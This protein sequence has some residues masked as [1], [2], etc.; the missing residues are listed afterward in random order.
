MRNILLD[1][2]WKIQTTVCWGR[3]DRWF[4]YD[5]VEEFCKDSKHNLI[6]L[7]MVVTASSYAFAEKLK[8]SIIKIDIIN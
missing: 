1:K 4:S 7:P 2:N 3:R 8:L 5:G 6:E